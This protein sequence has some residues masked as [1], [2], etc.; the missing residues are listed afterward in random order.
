MTFD[1][2]SDLNRVV[3]DLRARLAA[4]G[5]ETAAARLAAIQQTAFTTGSE[6]LGA[7]GLAVKAIRSERGLPADV[8]AGLEHIMTVV[9]RA[10]PAM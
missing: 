5:F 2:P 1:T 9:R 7:L 8:T 6:W 3:S 4:A 10:W